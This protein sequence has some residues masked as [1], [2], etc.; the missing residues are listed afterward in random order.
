LPGTLPPP[1]SL[2]LPLCLSPPLVIPLICGWLVG[3]TRCIIAIA[4]NVVVVAASLF[5]IRCNL[6][7]C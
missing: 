6:A 7:P 5:H 1:L 4:V 3:M 2:S